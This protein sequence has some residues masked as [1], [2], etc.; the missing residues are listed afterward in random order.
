MLNLAPGG[1]L[2]INAI[3]KEDTDKEYLLNIGYPTH[4]W[5][6]KEV[7]TVANVS[8]TDVSEFL[9]IAGEVP[10]KPEYHEFELIDANR[11]LL[12]VKTG[13]IRGAKVLHIS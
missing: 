12:E 11:A 3:R 4:L 6:E 8:R 7:K 9:R 13:K 5:L 10:I 1:R 2:V